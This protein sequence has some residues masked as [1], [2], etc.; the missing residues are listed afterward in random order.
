MLIFPTIKEYP[1]KG[2]VGL[3]G[4]ATGLLQTGAAVA[5]EISYILIAGGG[6]SGN[7]GNSSGAGGGGAGGRLTNI[8]GTALAMTGGVTYTITVGAGGSAKANGSN[9]TLVGTGTSLT[10]TGGGCGGYNQAGYAVGA[11][12]G[13]GGGGVNGVGGGAGL[14]G[15][16]VPPEPLRAGWPPPKIHIIL[17]LLESCADPLHY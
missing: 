11:T 4:G 15:S 3:G 5:P 17:F 2:L 16:T 12:G 9:S 6:G 14:D 13:S 8:G 1:I 10:A 7:G